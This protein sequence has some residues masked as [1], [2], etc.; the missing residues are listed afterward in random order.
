MAEPG[1]PWETFGLID[2]LFVRDDT[3]LGRELAERLPS[4]GAPR[5][6]GATDLLNPRRA[7]WRRIRGPAPLPLERQVRL[8]RGRRWHRALG[9]A[10][11]GEG[12]LEVRLRRGG[13]SA[14]IDLLADVP[15]EIKT[16]SV[17]SEGAPAEPW[18]DQVE[19]LAIYCA[20]T[21]SPVGRLAH[22]VVPDGAAPT[23]VLAEIAFRDLEGIRSEVGRRE[24]ALRSAIA[25]GVPRGLGRCRWVDRGCEYRA[26]AV[27]DC[28]GNEPDEGHSLAAHLEARSSRPEIAARWTD[29]LTAAA[30]PSDGSPPRFRD[31]LFPRRAYFDG[32]AGRPAAVYPPRPPV[33]PL[34]AYERAMAALEAAP[35]GEVHRLPTERRAPEEEVLAWRGAPVL[36]RSSRVP[37]RL[38]PD[39]LRRRFPQYLLDLGFRCGVTGTDHASLVVA[40]DSPRAGEPAIQVFRLELPGGPSR[41]ASAWASRRDALA[42]SIATRAP[43]A[44]PRCPAWMTADCPYRAE[45]GC[46]V[47]PGRS[48]R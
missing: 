33:A 32:T 25:S 22:L 36:V 18:P 17:P 3:V 48:Q 37:A 45:C 20:L 21:E 46:A 41:W 44:L 14:R 47:E 5:A 24:A 15:V 38:T 6:I 43:E 8:E 10:I 9:D 11:A 28:V 7:F 34:D 4:P 12:R 23:V 19:Q 1:E 42:R 13:L 40:H 2:E 31:L 30:A 39:D 16:V 35:A 29:A 26:G 27:C